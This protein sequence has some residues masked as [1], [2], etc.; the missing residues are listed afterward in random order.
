MTQK[1]LLPASICIIVSRVIPTCAAKRPCVRP[2]AVLEFELRLHRRV[3]ISFDSYNIHL[4]TIAVNMFYR[5]FW[6]EF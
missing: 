3:P 6:H 2:R 5:P 1:L 4:D